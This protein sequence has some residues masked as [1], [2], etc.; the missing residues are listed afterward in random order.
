VKILHIS[1]GFPPESVGGTETYVRDL[2]AAQRERGHQVL[3]VSGCKELRPVV[4]AE[5][6][7]EKGTRVIRL[8]RDDLYF[9]HYA[10]LYHPEISER[11]R[12][13]LAAEKP[14]LVHVHQW[15]R[16]TS[17]LVEIA[18]ELGIKTLVTLH[19]LYSSCPRCFRVNRDEEHCD[20][21]LSVESCFDCVPRFG[22]ESAAEIRESIQVFAAEFSAELCR[23][24]QVLVANQATAE[25]IAANTALDADEI[26]IQPIPYRPR[27]ARE[28][29]PGHG[30]GP[31]EPLRYAYWGSVTRRKGAQVLLEAYRELRAAE[32]DLPSELHVFGPVESAE[33]E[34]ELARLAAGMPVSFHGAF[35]LDEVAAQGIHVAVFPALGF[36]TYGL[37]L[38]EATE[39]GL[40]TILSDLGAMP[41]RAGKGAIRVGPG[42]VG[43]L[44]AA[45]GRMLHDPDSAQELRAHL[46]LPSP[47]PDE[48]ASELAEIYARCKLR[49]AME[50]RS[51][52]AARREA[53][54]Q[55]RLDS[56]RGQD[57][58]D[59]GPG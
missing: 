16:L 35:T 4:E 54:R 28:P 18:S 57:C 52:L 50:K 27:L 25:I 59:G 46:P 39:L 22:H 21:P 17:N 56:A 38:D 14:D 58:P 44:A 26:R 36:E 42:D 20:L 34:E 43:E 11:I 29:K 40:P 33:L 53:F 55:M 3:V 51:E 41:A 15:I 30:P 7:D 24:S 31:G 2:A 1:H 10:K 37:V 49:P 5:E 48:H 19:D 45:M 12:E 13:L 32:P 6:S 47:T 8:F 23:A 9:D